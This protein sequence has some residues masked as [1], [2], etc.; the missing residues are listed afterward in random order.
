MFG[1]LLSM[2]RLRLSMLGL[3]LPVL[4]LR[5]SMLGLLLSML[6]LKLERLEARLTEKWGLI[7]KLRNSRP[8]VRK[9]SED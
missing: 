2:L 9:R 6:V 3:L 5:L 8:Q 4:R 1:L 7:Q